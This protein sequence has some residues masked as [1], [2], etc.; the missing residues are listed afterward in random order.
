MEIESAIDSQQID[1]LNMLHFAG[2][3][4][5][6]YLDRSSAIT[7]SIN[8][9]KQHDF[10]PTLSE[11]QLI[12]KLTPWRA[13]ELVTEETLSPN[14]P[15]SL[16]QLASYRKKAQEAAIRVNQTVNPEAIPVLARLIDGTELASEE[17][18]EN[19]NEIV[20]QKL[21]IIAVH[22]IIELVSQNGGSFTK[23]EG[24]LPSNVKE[25]LMTVSSVRNFKMLAIE[26]PFEDTA[27]ID[28]ENLIDDTDW[29]VNNEAINFVAELEK[30]NSQIT[31][32]M[33]NF[34]NIQEITRYQHIWEQEGLDSSKLY[35]I[36]LSDTTQLVK[37]MIK[38]MTWA[39]QADLHTSKDLAGAKQDFAHW[40]KSLINSERADYIGKY[41]N[42]ENREQISA[43]VRI[44]EE[45]IFGK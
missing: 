32:I 14:I 13:I 41:M 39:T 2:K 11:N 1:T 15:D 34:K 26:G 21:G 3:E 44:A 33:R 28:G 27:F 6:V 4:S 30:T 16:A 7:E 36:S 29:P 10:N 23:Y 20:H 19:A 22:K 17:N 18:L 31:E 25:Y 37:N 12:S 45:S 38:Y 35:R 8:Q 43:M 40:T 5:P 42:L 24:I 9:A